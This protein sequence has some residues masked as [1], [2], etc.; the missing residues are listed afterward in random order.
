MC[1]ARLLALQDGIFRSLVLKYA[2]INGWR[3]SPDLVHS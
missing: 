1:Y 3:M 2:T